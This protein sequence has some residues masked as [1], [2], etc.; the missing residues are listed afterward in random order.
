MYSVSSVQMV[1]CRGRSFLATTRKEPKN[2]LR[3]GALNVV[4][5]PWAA[6]GRITPTPKRPPLGTPP[7][8][9]RQLNA[10][11]SGFIVGECCRAQRIIILNDCRWQ[12]YL[13]SLID[14]PPATSPHPPHPRLSRRGGYQPP[15]SCGYDPPLPTFSDPVT[16]PSHRTYPCSP[17]SHPLMPPL[18]RGGGFLPR[19]KAGGVV[20]QFRFLT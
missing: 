11:R 1:P 17:G 9:A 7:A 6:I 20:K 13:D 5:P 8:A 4:Y 14:R 2:R 15:V 3:G 12:S 19:Q 18:V 10:Q 16:S